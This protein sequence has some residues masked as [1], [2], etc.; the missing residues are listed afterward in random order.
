MATPVAE[1]NHTWD[2][3]N[4]TKSAAACAILLYVLGL[5]T[6]N[7]YLA[8]YGASDFTLLRARFVYTGA[9]ALS[10]LA[11]FVVGLIVLESSLRLDRLTSLGPKTRRLLRPVG[12]LIV[13]SITWSIF[14][15]ALN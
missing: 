6:V 11:V 9:L 4:I 12:F 5:V 15:F 3:E 1:A 13:C 10:P 8:P 14:L 2:A 7:E